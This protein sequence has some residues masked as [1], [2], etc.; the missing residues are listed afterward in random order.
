MKSKPHLQRYPKKWD[1][2]INQ[3]RVSIYR[4]EIAWLKSVF[5]MLLL[6]QVYYRHSPW[7]WCKLLITRAWGCAHIR[8]VPCQKQV[9]WAAACNY[10]WQYLWEVITC[11]CPWY[12]FPTQYS[13][14]E[15]HPNLKSRK[16]LF[17]HIYI[18]FSVVNPFWSFTSSIVL[19]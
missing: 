3:I 18:S 17:H 14:S 1:E 19:I 7:I 9:S 2:K 13:S 12:S 8:G 16:I 5:K 6:L 10:I 4:T 15:T 11:P